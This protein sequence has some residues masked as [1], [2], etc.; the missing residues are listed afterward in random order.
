MD[1]FISEYVKKRSDS[2]EKRAKLEKLGDLFRQGTTST[3]S[4]SAPYPSSVPPAKPVSQTSNT[5]YSAAGYPG[6]YGG[7]IAPYPN[8]PYSGMPMPGYYQR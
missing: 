7:N 6:G 4:S 3:G 5:G 2:Y 8:N 1:T